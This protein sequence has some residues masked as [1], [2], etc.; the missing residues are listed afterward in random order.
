MEAKPKVKLNKNL[1]DKAKDYASSQNRSLSQINE[2]LISHTNSGDEDEIQIS[3]FVKSMTTNVH[4]PID[5]DSK[6]Q[7][8]NYISE[9]YK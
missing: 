6:K 8:N 1:T 9:K 7:Y 3:A 4:I 2:S 5:F